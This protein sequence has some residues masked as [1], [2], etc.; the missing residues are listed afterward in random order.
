MVLDYLFLLQY[1][2]NVII[3]DLKN[4]ESVEHQFAYTQFP[5][6]GST[7]TQFPKKTGSTYT[8]VSLVCVCLSVL[9]DLHFPFPF[10]ARDSPSKQNLF[11]SGHV[12]F[13][14]KYTYIDIHKYTH[15]YTH[16]SIYP[17][18]TYIYIYILYPYNLT[19]EEEETKA[20]EKES[21]NETEEE[22]G[23]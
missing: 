4:N 7:Y 12:I 10:I 22:E 21:E 18:Y 16:T 13:L 2:L 3:V 11:I 17:Y 23:E 8:R 1:T 19:Q 6:P 14:G 5:K 9:L 15:R 20:K